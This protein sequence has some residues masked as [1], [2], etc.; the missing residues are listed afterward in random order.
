[1]S[2]LPDACPPRAGALGTCG[3]A[4]QDADFLTAWPGVS[5]PLTGPGG[6]SVDSSWDLVC[7]GDE[8]SAATPTQ[9]G[10]SRGRPRAT[11]LQRRSLQG[12]GPAWG[13]AGKGLVIDAPSASTKRKRTPGPARPR[14]G[15][16]PLQR[17]ASQG[18]G[19]SARGP[20]A[21]AL[22]PPR[23][24][25][26]EPG[27]PSPGSRASSPP[28]RPAAGPLPICWRAQGESA[29]SRLEAAADLA[30]GARKFLSRP[31]VRGFPGPGL[32]F[33]GHGRLTFPLRSRKLSPT[34]GARVVSWG[35]RGGGQK[36]APR[37]G[38]PGLRAWT[39]LDRRPG[40]RPQGPCRDDPGLGRASGLRAALGAGTRGQR[41]RPG[42][43]GTRRRRRGVDEGARQRQRRDRASV[44][45][46]A[47]G[48]A[49]GARSRSARMSTLALGSPGAFLSGG[50]E[51]PDL[52]AAPPEGQRPGPGPC[53]FGA[54]RRPP[55]GSLGVPQP[56]HGL[57]LAPPR[58]HRSGPF[59]GPTPGSPTPCQAA[60]S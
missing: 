27:P 56:R 55:H 13:P 44:S 57:P 20:A 6:G 48:L 52:R 23:Q 47:F 11:G 54:L 40:S 14:C 58:S 37:L 28:A 33:G 15:G 24:L 46:A 49:P 45:G 42:G 30:R 12:R 53:R 21:P 2:L 5:W 41:P 35:P 51:T 26:A 60:A 22:P 10:S 9:D 1:M 8:V 59:S 16:R 36:R 39:R 31:A 4:E 25:A 50:T 17:P 29:G 3:P 34:H 18:G 7:S 32:G 43:R 38:T 19:R